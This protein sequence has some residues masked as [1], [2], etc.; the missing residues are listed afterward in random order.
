MA[1]PVSSKDFDV[2]V[3]DELDNLVEDIVLGLC[4]ETHRAA[5]H[6]YLFIDDDDAE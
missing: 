5:K 4:F 3:E 6:G 2:V 1:A